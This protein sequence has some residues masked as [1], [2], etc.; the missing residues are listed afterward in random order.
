MGPKCKT[1][2]I[3]DFQK[4]LFIRNTLRSEIKD[5]ISYLGYPDAVKML[6][7][8]LIMNTRQRKEIGRFGEY[9]FTYSSLMKRKMHEKEEFQNMKYF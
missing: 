4:S 1:L 2:L 7:V 8:F 6:P 5:G 3:L 9:Q